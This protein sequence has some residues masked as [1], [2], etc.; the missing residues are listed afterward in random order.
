MSRKDAG[1]D[2]RPD[3][4]RADERGDELLV[5]MAYFFGIH[6]SANSNSYNPL[7]NGTFSNDICRHLRK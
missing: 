4:L 5:C 7:D 1:A 6:W 3:V 2:V